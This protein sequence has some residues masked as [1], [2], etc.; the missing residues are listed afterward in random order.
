[1]P[2]DGRSAYAFVAES[3]TLEDGTEA[4]TIIDWLSTFAE[5]WVGV[6]EYSFHYS[7]NRS[8]HLHTSKF[9]SADELDDLRQMAKEFN[10]ECNADL[11]TS[12]YKKNAQFRLIGAEHQKTGMHKVPITAN[13][14]RADCIK[15]AQQPP[16]RKQWPFTLPRPTH[17]DEDTLDRLASQFPLSNPPTSHYRPGFA[18]MSPLPSEI[19]GQVLRGVYKSPKEGSVD[20][21]PYA[22][23]FS[24]YKKTGTSNR[25]SIIVMKQ[26]GGLRQD[27]NTRDIYVPAQIKYAV[28][29]G[30]G[31]FT[32]S[33]SKSL[34][35][36][37]PRDFQKWVYE[38]GDT[39]IIIGGNSGS[40]RIFEVEEITAILV[41][42]ALEVEGRTKALEILSNRGYEIGSSG[43]HGSRFHDESQRAGET[44]AAKIKREIESGT[45]ERTY[46][47]ILRVACRLLRIEGW[48]AAYEWCRETFGTDFDPKRTHK[49]LKDLV[50]TYDDYSHVAVPE[51]PK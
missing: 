24:P 35:K 49:Q 32:R 46:E 42:N 16:D 20:F 17:H 14:D 11:D 36:L 6:D 40:S 15:A 25:R 48:D 37:S 3:D 41:S 28:G 9:I 47:N 29:G 21:G 5:D 27:R 30:D 38:E 10:E 23:P 22:R 51:E 50:E 13:A 33:E 44:D 43:Y 7:G 1:V 31:S 8:I 45:R 4:Q 34:V 26:D 2:R 39:V 19:E 18:A 12:V